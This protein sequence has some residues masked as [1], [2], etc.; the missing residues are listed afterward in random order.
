MHEIYT[1]FCNEGG[2]DYKERKNCTGREL[3]N[4]DS[5]SF[6]YFGGNKI[7][8]YETLENRRDIILLSW[9]EI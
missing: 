6:Y 4:H 7:K 5:G 2:K 3:G 1:A 9:K 8:K